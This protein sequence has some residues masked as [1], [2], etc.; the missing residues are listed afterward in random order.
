MRKFVCMSKIENADDDE[1]PEESFLPDFNHSD[2]VRILE[3]EIIDENSFQQQFEVL[4]SKA[5]RVTFDSED[6]QDLK[7]MFASYCNMKA[8]TTVSPSGKNA[9]VVA[10]GNQVYA[11]NRYRGSSPYSYVIARWHSEENNKQFRP[12][13]IQDLFEI[14]ASGDDMKMKTFWVAHLK[15]FKELESASDKFHYGN[16]AHVTLWDTHG[17]RQK[18]IHSCTIH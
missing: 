6:L 2:A 15:W 8:I 4:R 9:L 14:E 1:N 13:V 7:R 3:S 16:D 11:C 10:V 18:H 5:H 12:A 17:T